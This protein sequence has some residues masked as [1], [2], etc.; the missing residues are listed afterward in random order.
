MV[1]F[2]TGV[3]WVFV[4]A[5]KLSVTFGKAT[6]FQFKMFQ[7]TADYAEALVQASPPHFGACRMQVS[8][9]FTACAFQSVPRAFSSLIPRRRFRSSTDTVIV[10]YSFGQ[11]LVGQHSQPVLLPWSSASNLYV[12]R[13]VKRHTW[14]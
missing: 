13:E 12:A 11:R 9:A 7:F 5:R 6:D 2:W 4:E 1:Q 8:S 10:L 3:M 14:T